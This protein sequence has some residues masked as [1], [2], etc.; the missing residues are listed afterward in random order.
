[1]P[2]VIKRCSQPTSNLP[3]ERPFDSAVRGG[4]VNGRTGNTVRAS[5]AA[6]QKNVTAQLVLANIHSSAPPPTIIPRR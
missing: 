3:G 2:G 1:M 4:S 6:M 5:K